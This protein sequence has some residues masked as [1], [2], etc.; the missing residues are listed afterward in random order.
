VNDELVT[1]L[2]SQLFEGVAE[3]IVDTYVHGK[4]REKQTSGAPFSG[5]AINKTVSESSRTT[6]SRVLYD[7]MYTQLEEK[8][9]PKIVEP[10]VLTRRTC[11]SALDG[12]SIVKITGEAAVAD[13]SFLRTI[14]E[15]WESIADA[16]VAAQTMEK[17]EKRN[18]KQQ[19]VKQQLKTTNDRNEEAR[20]EK[21]LEKLPSE[22]ELREAVEEQLGLH[23]MVEWNEDHLSLVLQIWYGN[24]FEVAIERNKDENVAFR[25]ALRSDGLRQERSIR[26][27]S[28][29]GRTLR[30]EW[31]MVGLI[32]S[33]PEEPPDPQDTKG[34]PPGHK[35]DESLLRDNFRDLL[36]R[37]DQLNKL[38]YRSG[39]RKE[40][41][42][43]PLA[44]YQSLTM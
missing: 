43:R 23:E 37:L 3:E 10:E 15:N 21:V 28:N 35:E 20:L 38:M 9:K 5:E 39:T 16:L 7:H 26:R 40:V 32:Q 30:D 13:F 24:S 31:T 33:V 41:L 11:T 2:Y 27:L 12:V 8:I 14:L 44:L 34:P 25:G 19:Q 22:D 6:Q 4:S 1:S 29:A 36:Q 42:I 17:E 18:A